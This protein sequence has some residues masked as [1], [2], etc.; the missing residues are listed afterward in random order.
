M[1]LSYH[2]VASWLDS[3]HVQFVVQRLYRWNTEEN[4]IYTEVDWEWVIEWKW[5]G[6]VRGIWDS[7]K[8]QR[9]TKV[10]KWG[11]RRSSYLL[12][13]STLGSY[14]LGSWES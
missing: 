1:C 8:V 10:G 11:W 3:S 2:A 13:G 12:R 5:R 7:K 14:T 4:R 9:G 6:T